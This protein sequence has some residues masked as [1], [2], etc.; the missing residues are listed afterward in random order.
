MMEV[1]RAGPLVR[2]NLALV[3]EAPGAYGASVGRFPGVG[4]LVRRN[5]ALVAEPHRAHRASVGLIARMGP[6]VPTTRVV[7]GRLRAGVDLQ[8]EAN[9]RSVQSSNEAI[10]ISA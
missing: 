8:R 1:R 4:P 9:S 2:D 10:P 6:L 5:L 7:Y 3:G